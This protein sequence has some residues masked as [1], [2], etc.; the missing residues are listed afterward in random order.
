VDF[1]N[2]QLAEIGS[3]FRLG[4]VTFTKETIP[5]EELEARSKAVLSKEGALKPTASLMN[6]EGDLIIVLSDGDFVSFTGPFLSDGR[7]L[8]GI[9]SFQVPPLRFTNVGRN[10]IA[11][12]LG[13]AIGLG[14]N[15]DPANLMCG[16]PA[17]CR[18]DAFRSDVERYF[19]L[20]EE[21]KQ[22]LLKLYPPT[23]N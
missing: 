23:W 1:W 21:E 19:P 10:V 9:R 15:D 18:P 11:H 4:P 12:E 13:H 14:H 7:R 5:A 16:R 20:M 17:P 3:G 6:I 22:F 8:I 2:K